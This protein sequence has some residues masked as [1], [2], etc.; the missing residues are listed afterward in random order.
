MYLVRR[1]LSLRVASYSC[2]SAS[3]ELPR[4]ELIE[5]SPVLLFTPEEYE[6]HGKYTVLDHYTFKW[7]DGRMALALGLGMLIVRIRPDACLRFAGSIFNHSKIPNISYTMDPDTESIR[8]AT[9][10]VIEEGEELCIF[11][12]HKLWFEP[13]D[14]E[15]EI[16]KSEEPDDGWGGLSLVGGE[17]TTG[18]DHLA[19]LL[20]GPDDDIIPDDQL[21]F[22][23][24]K[25]VD[26]EAEDDP[27][28]VR[29]GPYSKTAHDRA[30]NII[31]R[32]R[33]GCGHLRTTTYQR[34]AKVCFW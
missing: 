3:R 22:T 19:S 17:E 13:V 10:R 9:T 8:Y 21:P 32:V 34:T 29:T 25:L 1:A 5:I 28:A 12:G 16:R 7:R 24:M 6:A 4:K 18:Y 15:P 33:V 14:V 2:C 27:N 30:A 23:R 26:D 11:Y 20:D 31:S